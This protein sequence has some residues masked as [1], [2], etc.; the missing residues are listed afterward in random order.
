MKRS[1]Y[2]PCTHC[3][4]EFIAS[5]SVRSHFL[6][7][8]RPA[9]CSPACKEAAAEARRKPIPV[10]GPC[11][12][13]GEM[14][15]SRQRKIF[16]GMKCY[17]ASPQFKAH[18]KAAAEKGAASSAKISHAAW[19][20]QTF[21]KCLEC[22]EEV[23][24]RGKHRKFCNH[25]CYRLYMAGRFD[26]WIASPQRI[27]TLQGYDEFLTQE[28]LP[29]LVEGCEWTGHALS[30]HMNFAHGVPA[31]EFKR[32]AGF[33]MGTGVVSQPMR[34]HL[35][36]RE[37]IG[38]AN[39]AVLAANRPVGMPV[40]TNPRGYLAREGKEHFAKTRAMLL[41]VEGP[42]RV[43]LG[44]EKQF[45]QATIYG[46]TKF[47]SVPCRTEWYRQRGMASRRRPSERPRSPD[48]TFLPGA[49]DKGEPQ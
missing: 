22:G 34:E 32:A 36:E 29:C 3:N 48:G 31:D 9:Y 45:K 17:T 30:N 43:C 37:H 26:R 47:C 19:L 40:P 1:P 13:C 33:N 39:A 35:Q 4:A 2:I 25:K 44:C 10:W 18:L 8:G 6:S 21:P 46:M 23:R 42:V 14:F 11:P 38:V 5:D 49:D 16:C 15:E 20:A 12:V 24:K 41:A 28:E 27:G 7:E